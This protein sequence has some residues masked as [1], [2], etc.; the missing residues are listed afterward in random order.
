[1][2][3]ISK[4]GMGITRTFLYYT[5]NL[6]PEGFAHKIRTHLQNHANEYS[7]PIISVS[8]KPINFGT[9]ICVGDIGVC[10]YNVYWQIYQ[11]IKLVTT[12]YVVCCEDDALYS[13]SHLLHTPYHDDIFYYDWNRWLIDRTNFWHK[14][15]RTVMSMCISSTKLML[16][17]LAEKFIKYPNK[18]TKMWRYFGEPGKYEEALGVTL[19]RREFFNTDN[20]SLTFNHKNNLGGQRK[21][22]PEKDDLTDYLPY[23]GKASDLW[24]EYYG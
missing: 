2:G 7:I 15:N 9:N 19:R 11:G 24:K 13:N 4:N 3:G 16:E 20:P 17:T 22:Y 18:D 10:N 14:D 8:Q 12:D 21:K 5:A 1:M 6:I 23:W